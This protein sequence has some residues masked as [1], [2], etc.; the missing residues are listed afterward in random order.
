[1]KFFS[2]FALPKK[3]STLFPA[4]HTQL[5]TTEFGRLTPVLC[6]EVLPGDT[7]D[8]NTIQTYV[9]FAPLIGP[10]Y[11]RCDCKVATFF[12]PNRLLWSDWEDFITG[13]DDT[14]VPP[15]YSLVNLLSESSQTI[16]EQTA[17]QEFLRIL[18]Y[19]GVGVNYTMGTQEM[20]ELATQMVE[21]GVDYS[22][23]ALPHRAYIRCW[24]DYFRD[25]T[26]ITDDVEDDYIKMT[27]G[28][29]AYNRGDRIF[30]TQWVCWTKDYFTV[31][32]ADPTNG[33]DPVVPVDINYKSGDTNLFKT[34]TGSAIAVSAGT[35]LSPSTGT[36]KTGSTNIN[37]DNSHSL[38]GTFSIDVLRKVSAI[39]RW[40]ERNAVAGSRY[41]TQ[42][43][44]HFGVVSDD[45]RLQR[46][47]LLDFSTFPIQISE[48]TSTAATDLADLGSFAGKGI[49]IGN[50]GSSHFYSKEHGFIISILWIVPRTSYFQGIPKM[51]SRMDKYDYYWPEFANIGYQPILTQEV[52]TEAGS[53]DSVVD[54]GFVDGQQTFGYLPYGSE[55]KFF[56]D[57]ISGEFA[58]SSTLSDYHN[59]R[60]FS[61]YP[62]NNQNFRKVSPSEMN[63]IFNVISNVN[64]HIWV[65]CD[66]DMKVSRQ[67]PE[68]TAPILH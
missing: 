6:Q 21:E 7:W 5:T 29:Q 66:F 62:G 10:C 16:A 34:T 41:I 11:S 46:A 23:N 20:D 3:E 18:N 45:A 13:N 40:L 37:V 49:G 61:D 53:L 14:L 39:T 60:I 52:Y 4:S 48:V 54:H 47:E 44:A 50:S 32:V 63:R 12:V 57:Q 9:R 56:P 58:W 8:I 38:T 2:E 36:I 55:Y 65:Q 26:Q 15:Y 25:S 17:L 33:V 28:V 22:I 19:L 31:A 27:G 67:M 64:D 42:L 30:D 35:L 51:F 59:A 24:W 68:F 1:M 43:L